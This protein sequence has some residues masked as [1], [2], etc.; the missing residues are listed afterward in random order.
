[1]HRLSVQRKRSSVG[2][3]M[4]HVKAL[5]ALIGGCDRHI[6]RSQAPAPTFGFQHSDKQAAKA[7]AAQRWF[8]HDREQFPC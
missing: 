2:E 4:T 3:A 7:K 5:S 8:H 1:M 6:E